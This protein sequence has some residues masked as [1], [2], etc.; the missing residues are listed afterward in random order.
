MKKHSIIITTLM[1]VFF[2]SCSSNSKS[3]NDSDT[4]PDADSGGNDTETIDEDADFQE[5]DVLDDDYKTDDSDSESSLPD[6]D[7]D[8]CEK[9]DY[10]SN[11]ELSDDPYCEEYGEYADRIA[12]RF[13]KDEPLRGDDP[14]HVKDLW[15]TLCGVDKCCD[16]CKPRPYDLCPSEYPFEAALTYFH[17]KEGLS[18]GIKKAKFQCDAQ[19]TPGLWTLPS[20][21]ISFQMNLLNGKLQFNPRNNAPIQYDS[22]QSLATYVY[23]LDTRKLERIGGP[24]MEGW[25]NSRYYFISTFDWRISDQ[26]ESP[27]YEMGNKEFVVYYDKETNTYGYAFKSDEIPSSTIDLRASE[28]Y[29]FMSANFAKYYEIGGEEYYSNDRRILYT[30][31]GEWDNWKELK[32]KKE[33]EVEDERR[34]GYPSMIDDYVVYFDQDLEIQFCDLSKGDEGCFKVSRDDEYGRYPIFKDKNTV[35]Y[36]SEKKSNA[37]SDASIVQADITDKNNIKY[38]TLYEWSGL[39]SV[40]PS[41]VDGNT[42]L[43]MRKYLHDGENFDSSSPEEYNKDACFYNFAEKTTVCMDE[44]FDLQMIKDDGYKYK[45]YYVFHSFSDVLVRDLEC[46]CDFYPEKCPLIDYTPNP[47][48][49]KEPWKRE[50]GK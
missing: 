1:F 36:S 32:Y 46:Y 39:Y 25:Q 9:P 7:S 22:V 26:K 31:I 23:D 48:N 28:N 14:E 12:Y 20:I 42:L 45:H 17:Y 4:I 29:L 5:P 43:F 34:A 33:N 40:Q 8:D 10:D 13:Y 19:L 35:I 11:F 21:A 15:S 18:S 2:V 44:N 24:Q 16:E 30:K 38:E 27:Y 3:N 49:P 6:S 50:C 41:N 37:D 47:D